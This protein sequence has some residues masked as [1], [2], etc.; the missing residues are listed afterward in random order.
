M[1][2]LQMYAKATKRKQLIFVKR[3]K[4][5]G[6]RQSYGMWL[7][8][9]LVDYISE[10]WLVSGWTPQEVPQTIS[11]NLQSKMLVYSI[12]CSIK[13]KKECTLVL[14]NLFYLLERLDKGFVSVAYV[15][16]YLSQQ[17][18]FCLVCFTSNNREQHEQKES[19]FEVINSGLV[20]YL[21]VEFSRFDSNADIR[22][23]LHQLN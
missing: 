11:K 8:Y 10:T 1:L 3:K 19:W 14:L 23:D 16:L 20:V 12:D 7:L 6:K 9:L 15:E 4:K 22:N 5:R 17:T 2:L 21:G 13:I 18:L